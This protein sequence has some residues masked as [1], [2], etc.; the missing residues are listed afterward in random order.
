MNLHTAPVD[1]STAEFVLFFL[2]ITSIQSALEQHTDLSTQLYCWSVGSAVQEHPRNDEEKDGDKKRNV[3]SA[4]ATLRH[5]PYLTHSSNIRSTDRKDFISF[6][7]LRDEMLTVK[8]VLS[9]WVST[10]SLIIHI[11]EIFWNTIFSWLHTY[12]AVKVKL[13]FLYRDF[14]IMVVLCG[15][16]WI[17]RFLYPLIGKLS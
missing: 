15:C 1:F 4:T 10:S 13:M 9:Q 5:L 12:G 14:N 2:P 3:L 8:V 11:S 17:V 16:T 7:S 6:R